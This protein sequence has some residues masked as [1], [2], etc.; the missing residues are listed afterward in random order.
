[1]LALLGLG[2]LVFTR[3]RVSFDADWMWPVPPILV[4]GVRYNPVITDG[5][6]VRSGGVTHPGVDIVYPRRSPSDLA[7]RF[8]VGTPN[9]GRTWFAP[10]PPGAKTPVPV[11]AARAG[12]VWSVEKTAR[13][14]AVVIDHGNPFATFYQH[15]EDVDLPRHKSGKNLATGAETRIAMGQRIGVMGFSPQDAERVRHLHF[16]VWHSGSADAAIDPE[17][18]M[19]SWSLAQPFTVENG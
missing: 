7:Q 18:A 14:W 15:L 5:W 8:P 3:K 16:E 11:L 6:G 2:L 10:G 13:G 17:A 1:M 4:G 9:G 12:K 19:S